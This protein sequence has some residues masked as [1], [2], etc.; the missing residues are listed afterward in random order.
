MSESIE[1]VK[2]AV[3]HLN[4]KNNSLI[5]LHCNSAYPAKLNEL[6]LKVISTYKKLFN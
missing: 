2:I 5:L 4:K 1:D 6:N 3:K